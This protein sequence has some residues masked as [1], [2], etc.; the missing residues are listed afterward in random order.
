MNVSVP[1][2]ERGDVQAWQGGGGCE[3]NGLAF[4]SFD[5]ER[6]EGNATRVFRGDIVDGN[7]QNVT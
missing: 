6:D 7:L 4:S 5:S 3:W 2:A 1:L